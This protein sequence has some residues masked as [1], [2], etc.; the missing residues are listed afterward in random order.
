MAAL[1]KL[2]KKFSLQLEE[3]QKK[4][5]VSYTHI[6]LNVYYVQGSHPSTPRGG[7]VANR[8]VEKLKQVI[9]K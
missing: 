5:H 7:G 2:E 1:N 3:A 4:D 9:F 6:A 8:H